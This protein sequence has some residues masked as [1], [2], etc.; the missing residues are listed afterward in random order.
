MICISSMT[1]V[2][3]KTAVRGVSSW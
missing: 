1:A 2:T 3:N